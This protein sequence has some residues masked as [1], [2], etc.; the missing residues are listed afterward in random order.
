MKKEKLIALFL[1]LS[2]LIS[3]ATILVACD[4]Q[5][6]IPLYQGSHVLNIEYQETEGVV[7]S[8][9]DTYKQFDK[10]QYADLKL[11]VFGYEA[12][13]SF[14]SKEFFKT[15]KLI[16]VRFNAKANAE[17]FIKSLT[18][19]DDQYNVELSRLNYGETDEQATYACFLELEIT[20]S[21]SDPKVKLDIVEERQV[22]ST[23]TSENNSINENVVVNRLVTYEDKSAYTSGLSQTSSIFLNRFDEE[24]FNTKDLLVID[25]VAYSYSTSALDFDGNSINL[26]VY[27]TEHYRNEDDT[28]RRL[29]LYIEID[30]DSMIKNI[31]YFSYWEA[32]LNS[33]DRTTAIQVVI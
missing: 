11:S 31:N 1:T 13:N 27:N 18:Y 24:F 25:Y 26:Y 28:N 23:L 16:V 3:L 10:S 14:Y 22:V 29:I 6:S 7:V 19:K 12:R 32:E 30:K 4:E 20:N 15:R 2:L 17:Y 9:Y 5:I 21:V 33:E 8:G